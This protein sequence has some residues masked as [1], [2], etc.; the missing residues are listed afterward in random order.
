MKAKF[1]QQ[2]LLSGFITAIATGSNVAMADMADKLSFEANLQSSVLIP[3]SFSSSNVLSSQV[4]AQRPGGGQRP[5]GAPRP[6]GG[7]G[8]PQNPQGG[9]GPNPQGGGAPA[10]APA[11]APTP[12]P[13]PEPAPTQADTQL[14]ELIV[15]RNL[16]VSPTAGR[17]L[18]SH[19]IM[20]QLGKALFFANNLGG[21]NSVSCASCHHPNLGGGDEL[22]LPV[23]VDAVDVD[24]QLSPALLGHGRFQG[25][26]DGNRPVIGRNSPTVFNMGLFDRSLFWDSRVEVINPVAGSNGVGRP[27]VTPDSSVDEQGRRL[28]DSNL[29]QGTTLPAAQARFPVTSTQEMRGQFAAQADNQALRA[30]L[31]TRF[32]NSDVSYDSSWPVLFGQTYDDGEINFD[33]IAHAIGEYERSMTFVNN[34]WQ[35]YLAGDNSAMSEQQKQGAIL[36]F[37]PPQQGGVGCAGCHNGPTFSDGRHHLTA[38]PQIGPGAGDTGVAG[39]SDDFGRE[40]VTGNEADR[41]HFRT[42][43]LLNVAVTA[44]YGHSGAYET[45]AQVVNHYR[46]PRGS[47]DRLFGVVN[48]QPFANGD[49]PLCHSAQVEAISQKNGLSCDEV[50]PNAFANSSAAVRRLGQARNGQVAA[51]APLP[52]NAPLDNARA[53]AIVAFLHALTDPCVTDSDCMQPWVI[54]QDD[55]ATYPDDNPM[56]AHDA[57]GDAL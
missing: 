17:D 48:G 41:Y 5:G 14:R 56:V 13:A 33:R 1:K 23:G 30:Q 46:N 47:V 43:S 26:S 37:S 19:D 7:G 18:P 52:A 29:P 49:A 36:F 3:Q 31:A 44:P 6:G 38:F 45:L 22:S 27:I 54:D 57:Q 15:A 4:L 53:E 9:G 51:T 28:P 12:A 39:P 11:P 35:A 24:D 8:N 10:P 16:N 25:Q 34:P 21:E 40:R 50:Y 20:V 55:V 32:D 2:L 42:P